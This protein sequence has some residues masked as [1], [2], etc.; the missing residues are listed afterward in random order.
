MREGELLLSDYSISV[1]QSRSKDSR[2]K[3]NAFAALQ[4]T[5]LIDAVSLT[6]T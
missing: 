2:L 1:K 6:V 3:L 4:H 5:W